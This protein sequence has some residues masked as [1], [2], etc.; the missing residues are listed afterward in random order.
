MKKITILLLVAILSI[1]NL[2]AQRLTDPIN[3]DPN[4]KIGKLS[5]GL[6]YYIRENKKPENRAEFWLVVNAGSMQ[7]NEDQLGLAH[8]VEHMGFNGI[9]GWPGNKLTD[10]LQK[11]GVSFGGGINA[12]TS[13]DETVYLLTMPTDNPK[14]VDMAMNILRSWSSDFLLDNKEIEE[15]RGIII[16]EYRGGLGADDRM[17][18]KW[19]PVL[20]NNSRYAERLPIGTLEVLENFKPQTLKNFYHDWYRPDLQAIIVVGDINAAEIE[21]MIH[22]KFG[23]IKPKKNPREKI[24]YPIEPAKNPVA[25]VATDKEAGANVVMTARLFPHFV[26][27]TVGDYRTKMKHELFN[28]MYAGRLEEMM[29]NPNTPFIGAAVGYGDFIGNTDAYFAHAVA[30]ENQIDASLKVLMQEDYRVLN[31]GFLESEF[32]RAKEEL[33]YQYEIAANETDKTESSVFAQAYQNHYLR[34][35]PIPGAKRVFNYAKRYLDEITLEEVNAL[36]KKWITK[37]NIVVIVTAPEKAGV[38]V[39]TEEELL[40]IVKDPSLANVEPYI[41]TYK[42][43]EIVEVETL[44][45]GKIVSEN[46]IAEVGVTEIILNNGITVWLKKT[47]FK[48]DEILFRA[49]SRGGMSLYSE[50]DLASGLFAANFIDR[51]GISDI[52]FVSLTKKMKGKQAGLAPNISIFTEEMAGTSTPKDLEFFFQY[53]HAFFASPRYDPAVYELV[54]KELTES[55]KM[56]NAVPMYRFLKNLVKIFTQNDFFSPIQFV[57]LAYTE[58]FI[59]SAN[60]DRAFEIYKERFANPADFIF[61]FVGNFDQK[62]MRDFLELY[63][64]SLPTSPVRDE[65]NPSVVK[66]FPREQ[67]NQD[68]F[69]GTE[70]QSFVGIV[71]QQEFTW[72][73]ENKTILHALN[74]A[75][76]IELIAEIREK[77]SGVYSPALVL[78]WNQLPRSEYLMIIFFGCN[79]NNTDNLANAVFKILREMQQNGPSEETMIKVKQQLIKQ[80]ETSVKTNDFWRQILTNMWIQ[81]DDVTTILEFEERVNKLTPND[82]ANFLQKYFDLE[83][84]VRVNMFPE[85]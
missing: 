56:I 28:L 38:I 42:E 5:N 13:F 57:Q 75:L 68:I 50:A 30:K 29:Q 15:E 23:K 4:V 76:Q 83:H 40:A 26:M 11:I 77:M 37:D 54:T 48:N 12:Y 7:E 20:F 19:F 53:L 73:E 9:K 32:K 44:Q 81:N 33:L 3:N 71:Y 16:E 58:D 84:Y 46:V 65:V 59:Y 60:Y 1:C 55:L 61:T 79:P 49:M 21:K 52:D 31:H 66:G 64:G 14:N 35:D 69:A 43:Q 10:E 45:R 36:A 72:T 24:I 2:T 80:R 22:A 70:E 41:D 85:R 8:F 27:K 78:T 39:P 25:V 63:L 18:K 74:D 67:I 82:I 6:T 62:I 34:Q 17:R 47:D 51:A